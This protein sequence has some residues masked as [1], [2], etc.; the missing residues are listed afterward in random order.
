LKTLHYDDETIGRY[1]LGA[2]SEEETERLDELSISD[3]EFAGRLS[4]AENDLVDAFVRGDLTG[5]TLE[6]FNS[7]YLSSP[8]RSEKAR[9]AKAFQE[10]AGRT[11]V[12]AEMESPGR[13]SQQIS[14]GEKHASGS[15]W[16]SGFFSFPRPLLLWGTACAALLIVTVGLW[17]VNQRLRDQMNTVKAERAALEQ[18]DLELQASLDEER[19]SASLREKEIDGLRDKVA[20]LE[21]RGPEPGIVPVLSD[22]PYTET[23]DL[24]PQT[25]GVPQIT[26][27]RVPSDADYVILNL[28]LEAGDYPSYRAELKSLPDR[29]VVWRSGRVRA[30]TKDDRRSLAVRFSP[31]VL[32][33]QA[34]VLDVTGISSSGAR[35][36]AGSYSFR[37]GRD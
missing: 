30:R 14:T 16:L 9:F 15:R 6:L 33:P 17:L 10:V 37:V 27:L 22:R 4:A 29:R 36:P 7:F 32:K 23:F 2:L 31:T 13:R 35:E 18:R 20:Q 24:S 5:Q 8:R 34:Y 21:R 1:L 3:D 19:S 25:R 26:T 11:A 28:E 12:A